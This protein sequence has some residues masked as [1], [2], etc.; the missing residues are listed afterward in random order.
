MRYCTLISAWPLS[1]WAR[2]APSGCN[3]VFD[4][5]SRVLDPQVSAMSGECD[6]T[7]NLG[8]SAGADSMT[9]G[10]GE[11]GLRRKTTRVSGVK[12]VS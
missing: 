10:R 6:M 4:E 11:F 8:L 12:G 3:S 2:C 1:A 7:Y 9:W 5:T